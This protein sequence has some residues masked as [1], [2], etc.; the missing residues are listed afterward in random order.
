MSW[1]PTQAC[2]VWT[3]EDEEAHVPFV[4]H[5]SL[6]RIMLTGGAEGTEIR[7]HLEPSLLGA[8]ETRFIDGCHPWSEGSATFAPSSRVDRGRA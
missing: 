8:S 6:Q 2:L 7:V 3:A 5:L 4:G 1:D